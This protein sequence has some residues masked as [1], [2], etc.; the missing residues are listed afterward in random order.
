MRVLGID[1]GSR[2]T[3]WGV[4]ERDHGRYV[5]IGAGA[6]VTDAAAPMPSR[7]LQ[8]HG[9]LSG[10]LALHA[11]D[12]VSIEQIF[13]YKSAA[14]ALVLGQ[15]RG[16]ALVA[17]A[18]AGRPVFEYNAST[19]KNSV[20]GSGSADKKAVARMVEMLIGT[21]IDGPA[22]AT[23]AVALAITHLAHASGPAVQTRTMAS[24]DAG[25]D[26]NASKGATAQQ[27][28]NAR[29]LALAFSRRRR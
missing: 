20:A 6:I 28:E 18:G 13:A 14:S 29:L 8:I 21:A 9:T 19:V 27:A 15:A 22:D 5:L 2:R 17:A 10:L 23:D 11:P 26:A 12:A 24:R 16:V 4:V 3:G 1:P 7:L 25:S